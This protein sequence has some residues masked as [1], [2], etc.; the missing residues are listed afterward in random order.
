MD[1]FWHRYLRRPYRL[2]K[3]IDYGTGPV[4]IILVHGLA[5]RS[6]IWNPLV[7]LLE[8]DKY[9]VRSFD[10]LGFGISP[11]PKYMSYSTKDH[12][13]AI[14][15]S[16]SK[17]RAKNEQFI[18]IG[19]SMGCIIT[20]QIAYKRPDL[21][22][23]VILY[24]PPLLLDAEEKRSIHKRFYKYLASKP[25]ALVAYSK[26]TNK[27]SNKLSGFKITD[28]YWLP[29]EN[30][31][32]NTIL[33]QQTLMQ[34]QSITKPTEIIYGRLD[35]LVSKIKAKKLAEINPRI[36]LHYVTEMHDIKPKSSRYLKRLI[37][38]LSEGL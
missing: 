36:R 26:L 11:K 10:L 14:L 6:E 33:A 4:N 38:N 31:L 27:F 12:T 2:E 17:E 21:V 19:H 35:F 37:E 22:K 13:R 23:G 3:V 25:S 29:I 1:T 28:E 8:I 5:S 9:R 15:H 32:Q 18:F 30:S 24:K 16:L 7:E 34:L 20:T